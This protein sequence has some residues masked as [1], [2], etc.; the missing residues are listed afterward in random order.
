MWVIQ[1][2]N[3]CLKRITNW[4]Y[5]SESFRRFLLGLLPL[6]S[7]NSLFKYHGVNHLANEA[8]KCRSIQ[9]TWMNERKTTKKACNYTMSIC[10]SY[11]IISKKKV[12]HSQMEGNLGHFKLWKILR[13]HIKSDW[14]F[15]FTF[16]KYRSGFSIIHIHRTQR[17][18]QRPTVYISMTEQ[19]RRVIEI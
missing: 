15:S 16:R 2:T 9:R 8:L 3:D 12:N 1:Q 18:A 19:R 5:R 17:S 7:W 14:F 10:L 4:S 13:C 11:Y 6:K